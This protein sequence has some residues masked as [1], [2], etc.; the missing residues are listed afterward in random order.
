M[1]RFLTDRQVDTW[2]RLVAHANDV[3]GIRLT[4]AADDP[5]RLGLTTWIGDGQNGERNAAFLIPA[6][7]EESASAA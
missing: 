4:E 1:I 5:A 7:E 3:P 6:Y 2:V